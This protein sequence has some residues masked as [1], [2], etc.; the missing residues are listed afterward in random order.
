MKRLALAL[1]TGALLLL[2]TPSLAYEKRG[3]YSAYSYPSYGYDRP[4]SSGYYRPY[5]NDG[6]YRPYTWG[7]SRPIVIYRQA[8]PN[9]WASW[10][11]RRTY[12]TRYRYDSGHT[13]RRGSDNDR[14]GWWGRHHDDDRD[15]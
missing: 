6:Y 14:N 1:A 8:L 7:Y 15:D 10:G 2:A 5:N 3:G 9:G 12:P 13:W 11:H 4:Y